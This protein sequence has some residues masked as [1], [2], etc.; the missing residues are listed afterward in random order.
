MFQKDYLELNRLYKQIL[1]GEGTG[2]FEEE[3]FVNFPAIYEVLEGYDNMSVENA[4]YSDE[5]RVH[6]ELIEKL[7][8]AL[9][10][11]VSDK[12][13]GPFFHE[14]EHGEGS[15]LWNARDAIKKARSF[16]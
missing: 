5:N 16:V 2:M 9:D 1:A 10:E 7:Y 8:K 4:A 6:L 13:D 11:M 15:A 12:Q 3:V 14:E